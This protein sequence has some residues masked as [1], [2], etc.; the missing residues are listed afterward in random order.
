MR[1]GEVV[2]R[3]P[4]EP[5]GYLWRECPSSNTVKSATCLPA[6]GVGPGRVRV[7]PV[8]TRECVFGKFVPRVSMRWEVCVWVSGV[9]KSN[10]VKDD[11]NIDIFFEI[12]KSNFDK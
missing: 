9:L 3:V 10:C 6:F 7:N 1:G 11:C 2:T 5:V 8:G 4:W 12:C